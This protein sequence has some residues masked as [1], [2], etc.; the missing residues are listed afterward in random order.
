M[1]GWSDRP[2]SR[3]G[4]ET[5][6]KA[7]IQAIPTFIMSYFQIPISICDALRKTI[8]DHWW[9]FEDRKKK[10]HWHS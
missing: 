4:K 8:A 9:G 1:N 6:L 7:I 2:M 10:M 3:A 5:L